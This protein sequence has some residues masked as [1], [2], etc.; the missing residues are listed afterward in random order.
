MPM[1]HPSYAYKEDSDVF[2]T[3]PHMKSIRIYFFLQ[4]VIYN[5]LIKIIEFVLHLR[6]NLKKE[7]YIVIVIF[8]ILATVRR[9]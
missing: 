4:P 9:T 6:V 1:N 2:V 3:R 5:L 7:M 8:V